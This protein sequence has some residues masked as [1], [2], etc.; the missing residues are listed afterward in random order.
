MYKRLN[1]LGWFSHRDDQYIRIQYTERQ[2]THST[3]L[4]EWNGLGEWGLGFSAGP[5]QYPSKNIT[6]PVTRHPYRRGAG[7]CVTVT[8]AWVKCT[9][10][11]CLLHVPVSIYYCTNFQDGFT[12]S[13]I[14]TQFADQFYFFIHYTLKPRL[15]GILVYPDGYPKKK[16]K[17][18]E[19]NT[20][21]SVS[22]R[23]RTCV[24][25][26][27]PWLYSARHI[28]DLTTHVSQTTDESSLSLTLFTSI[29]S[30]FLQ[31]FGLP[32][33]LSIWKDSGPIRTG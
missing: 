32:G 15:F 14:T 20:A 10:T 19:E 22:G 29:V 25:F 6:V 2:R 12:Y 5:N 26:W 18:C 16:L 23:A 27:R 21:L 1:R 24:P 11:Y 33:I 3:Q 31:A 8:K 4:W 30:Q 9:A 28:G 7:E 13:D 17:F